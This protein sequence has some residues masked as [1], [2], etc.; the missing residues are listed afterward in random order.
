MTLHIVERLRNCQ[1]AY[2]DH[3]PKQRALYGEAAD[4]ITE[5]VETLVVVDDA[6]RLYLKGNSTGYMQSTLL[7]VQVALVSAGAKID[8]VLSAIAAFNADDSRTHRSNPDP[9]EHCFA[10]LP[11]GD[12]DCDYE[13][14]SYSGVQG[15]RIGD[16]T[17]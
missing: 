8:P 14:V 10:R 17:S 7:A 16:S 15:V 4:I 12:T 3:R 1:R 11:V 2:W 13:I 6:L 9:R 5:L